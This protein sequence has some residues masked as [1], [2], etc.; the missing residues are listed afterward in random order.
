MGNFPQR[1]GNFPLPAGNF[2]MKIPETIELET[3][4]ARMPTY[5]DR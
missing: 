2:P 5:T 1:E 4:V 3:V